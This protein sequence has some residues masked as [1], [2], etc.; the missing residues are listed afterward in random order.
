MCIESDTSSEINMEEKKIDLNF[1]FK[2]KGKPPKFTN[3][4]VKGKGECDRC[5]CK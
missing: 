3:S 1:K 5:Y 2:S 4:K